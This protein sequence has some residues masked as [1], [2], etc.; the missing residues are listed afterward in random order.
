MP[1]EVGTS[2]VDLA[3]VLSRLADVV[4]DARD[5]SGDVDHARRLQTLRLAA[6]AACLT[7]MA[8]SREQALANA[9]LLDEMKSMIRRTIP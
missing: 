3:T 1:V 2:S 7:A 4:G 8:N 6:V 9:Q 5:R